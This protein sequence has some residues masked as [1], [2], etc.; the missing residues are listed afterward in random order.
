RPLP[1][2]AARRPRGR[3][4]LGTTP[5]TER[6]PE[7]PAAPPTTGSPSRQLLAIAQGSMSLAPRSSQGR[8]VA[9]VPEDSYPPIAQPAAAD[10]TSPAPH[11]LVA[12]TG[13]LRSRRRAVRTGG[14]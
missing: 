11:P 6:P 2:R 7:A 4:R 5:R 13:L 1:A 14:N 9:P 8:S 3:T 12:I 10:G